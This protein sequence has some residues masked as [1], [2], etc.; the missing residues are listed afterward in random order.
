MA[1]SPDEIRAIRKRAKL[2]QA[3][4]AEKLAVTRDSVASWEIGRSKP[5]GP[6]EIL[7][8]QIQAQLDATE[9]PAS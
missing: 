4:M 3:E 9:V 2:T 7:I 6:A 8:R 1:I 5:L